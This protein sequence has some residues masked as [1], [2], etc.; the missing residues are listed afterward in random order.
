MRSPSARSRSDTESRWRRGGA[1]RRGPA[2]IPSLRLAHEEN[3]IDLVHLEELDLDALVARRGQ[4]LADVVGPDGELA[5]PPVD[6]HGERDARGTT[7]LGQRVDRG[8]DRAPRVE[9]VVD[10]DD[11]DPLEAEGDARRPHDGLPVRRPSAGPPA[12]GAAGGG[13]GEGPRAG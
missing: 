13:G 8:P 3:A 10:E 12:R 2:T 5:V 1:R 4:V 7:E 6:E 9:D 11:G